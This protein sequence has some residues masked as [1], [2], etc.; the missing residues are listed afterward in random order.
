MTEPPINALN[1]IVWAKAQFVGVG[2]FPAKTYTS[3]EGDVWV[4]HDPGVPGYLD[5]VVWDGR[6]IVAVGQGGTVARSLDGNAWSAEF[7]GTW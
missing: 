2:G 6:G 3:P 1:D 5:R 4:E 7:A